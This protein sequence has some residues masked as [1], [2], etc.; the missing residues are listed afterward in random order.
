MRKAAFVH[1]LPSSFLRLHPFHMPFEGKP[2]VSRSDTRTASAAFQERRIALVTGILFTAH[3]LLPTA[4]YE[5][6]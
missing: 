1:S 3:C 6:G 2:A 5:N 4:Y